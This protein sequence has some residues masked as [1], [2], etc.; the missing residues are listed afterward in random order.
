M[1]YVSCQSTLQPQISDTRESRVVPHVHIL[2][3]WRRQ[4]HDLDV[5][6][7]RTVKS[8]RQ[9]FAGLLYGCSVEDRQRLTIVG[10]LTVLRYT[11]MTVRKAW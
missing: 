11:L 6:P 2:L 7:A 9:S 4:L 3:E 5:K 1:E 8:I 10:E